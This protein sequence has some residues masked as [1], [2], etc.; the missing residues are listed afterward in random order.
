MHVVFF[1]N[2]FLQKEKRV[3]S[4]EK[5][6]WYKIGRNFANTSAL[7]IEVSFNIENAKIITIW[8]QKIAQNIL[9]LFQLFLPVFFTFQ[10]LGLAEKI[11]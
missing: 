10:F 11:K 4:D 1:E 7:L 6:W 3:K 5:F 9:V 8:I 2:Y